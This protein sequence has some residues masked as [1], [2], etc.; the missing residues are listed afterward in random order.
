MDLEVEITEADYDAARATGATGTEL[1]E[2]AVHRTLDRLGIPR[3]GRAVKA[4]YDTIIIDLP[5]GY[6][7]PADDDGRA[8]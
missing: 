6:T 7:M 4:T 8:G 2:F 1:L 3:E 5:P